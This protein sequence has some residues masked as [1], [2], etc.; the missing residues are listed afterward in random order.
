MSKC[1][2]DACKKCGE[3]FLREK[4]EGNPY[5]SYKKLCPDCRESLYEQL[6]TGSTKPI[7]GHSSA[8]WNRLPRGFWSGSQF[9][10]EEEYYYES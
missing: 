6:E 8:D 9:F 4:I 5:T 7:K 3:P 10:K 2:L 1:D